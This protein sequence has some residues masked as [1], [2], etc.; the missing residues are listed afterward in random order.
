M[1]GRNIHITLNVYMKSSGEVGKTDT[2]MEIGKMLIQDIEDNIKAV[3]KYENITLQIATD[4]R[5]Y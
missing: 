5:V 4:I 3:C 2:A 1:N